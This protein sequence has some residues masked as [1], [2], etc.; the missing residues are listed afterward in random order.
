MQNNLGFESYVEI[1]THALQL[2]LPLRN[3]FSE[4]LGVNLRLFSPNSKTRGPAVFV[5]G[6]LEK[7]NL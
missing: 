1:Q 3:V 2:N 5:P 6:A 7:R 4:M